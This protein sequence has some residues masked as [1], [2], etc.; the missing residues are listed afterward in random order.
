MSC[1]NTTIDNKEIIYI[2]NPDKHIELFWLTM[3]NN[4]IN[5][6]KCYKSH[7]QNEIEKINDLSKTLNILQKN[8]QYSIIETSINDFLLFFTFEVI[9]S[10]EKYTLDILESN[11]KRWKTI[12]KKKSFIDLHNLQELQYTNNITNY[13]DIYV[14]SACKLYKYIDEC[15]NTTIQRDILDFFTN[16][17]INHTNYIIHRYVYLDDNINI[18]QNTQKNTQ[19]NTNIYKINKNIDLLINLSITYNLI[20]I[21]EKIYY[22]INIHKYIY[23]KY[24]ISNIPYITFTK[25]KSKKILNLIKQLEIKN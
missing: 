20:S 15:N 13:I 11:I 21:F 22:I 18:T 23:D 25:M 3:K 7:Y 9:E 17:K 24:N 5:F 14:S 19:K 8:K 6:Y 16:V 10:R 2:Q 12:R 4:M 1:K